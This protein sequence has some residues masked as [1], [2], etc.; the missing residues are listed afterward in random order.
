MTPELLISEGERLMRPCIIL[1]P[2]GD[3]PIVAIWH[4]PDKEEIEVTGYRCWITVD[5]RFVPGLPATINGFL[6]VFTNERKCQGGRIELGS[7]RPERPGI[8]LRAVRESVLP[9]IEA[10]FMQGSD[11]VEKWLAANEWPRDERYNHNFP[12]G[13]IVEQYEQEWH[14]Q[15]PLYRQDGIYAVLGGWHCPWADDDWYELMDEQL[16]VFTLHDS[17]PWIEAWRMRDG[18]FKVIQ[19]IT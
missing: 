7:E 12:D 4:D 18:Q 19:R 8:A 2:N 11:A 14:R 5:T 9:P 6:S 10:I 3:G 13:A 17:E 15:Y 1:R 16:M